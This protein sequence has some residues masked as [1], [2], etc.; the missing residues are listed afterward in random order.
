MAAETELCKLR[1]LITTVY[2]G[3]LDVNEVLED[4]S[5]CWT[6][7]H[8]KHI[9]SFFCI[10]LPARYWDY[11]PSAVI[12]VLKSNTSSNVIKDQN[13]W[14]LYNG[15]LASEKEEISHLA[16]SILRPF[17]ER[18][19]YYLMLQIA[20]RL[21]RKDVAQMVQWLSKID[22]LQFRYDIEK[23]YPRDGLEFLE[24]LREKDF[25]GAERVLLLIYIFEAQNNDNLSKLAADFLYPYH[26]GEQFAFPTF[27]RPEKIVW[28]FERL[29]PPNGCSSMPG[30]PISPGNFVRHAMENYKEN[31]LEHYDL[32]MR[33]GRREAFDYFCKC[34]ICGRMSCSRNNHFHYSGYVT[35][36]FVFDGCNHGPI[37]NFCVCNQFRCPL[38]GVQNV[39]PRRSAVSG[40]TK[41]VAQCNLVSGVHRI[42]ADLH[43][44]QSAGGEQQPLYLHA[45]CVTRGCGRAVISDIVNANHVKFCAATSFCPARNAISLDNLD[46]LEVETTMLPA[47]VDVLPKECLTELDTKPHET[48]DGSIQPVVCQ[49]KASSERA[50]CKICMDRVASMVLVPCGH[51]NYCAE[52]AAKLKE[53]AFCTRVIESRIRFY[54]G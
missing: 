51:A 37:C 31:R 6:S 24:Y 34:F 1:S 29:E 33:N 44:K 53:C 27:D 26:A 50:E 18:R 35:E 16:E 40:H 8:T 45:T 10:C 28:S 39:A 2:P 14:M 7:D 13:V 52:C 43:F 20:I 12:D 19:F 48:G 9:Y 11:R 4:L 21:E 36:C 5:A 25:I 49:D 15:L 54:I 32:L 42:L 30:D 23:R 22:D 46:G 47:P 17:M 3:E 41:R 38:C